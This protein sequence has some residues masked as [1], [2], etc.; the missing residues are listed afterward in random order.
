MA[1]SNETKKNY[2][3]LATKKNFNKNFEKIKI[4]FFFF[5]L[6]NNYKY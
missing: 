5:I 1:I 6:L 3:K 4:Q 2:I